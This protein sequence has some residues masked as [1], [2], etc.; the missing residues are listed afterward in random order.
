MHIVLIDVS[1]SDRIEL[2]KINLIKIV[3]AINIYEIIKVKIKKE[4]FIVYSS[5]IY[6]C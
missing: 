5:Y 6:I 2:F 4:M 3:N 1:K